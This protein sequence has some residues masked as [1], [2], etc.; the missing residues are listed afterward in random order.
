MTIVPSSRVGPKEVYRNPYMI[1]RHDVTRKLLI[2]TRTSAP[3]PTID[4]MRDTF[5]EMEAAIGYVSRPR[6]MLLIDARAALPRNDPDFEAEFGRL[7]KHF[8][9]EFQKIATLVQTAVGILQVTRQVRADER[10]TGAFTDPSEA[11]AYLGV[12][13]EPER[14]E[15]RG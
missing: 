3:Y 5:L 12:V 7:R 2:V 13:I 4:T 10:P 15:V 9:R 14:I 6:T 11:L 1:V 8:L